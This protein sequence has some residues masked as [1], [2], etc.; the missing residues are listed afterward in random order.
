[1]SKFIIISSSMAFIIWMSI[2]WEKSKKPFYNSSI[3]VNG[4]NAI[5]D[6][7]YLS[8]INQMTGQKVNDLSKKRLINALV[9][10][11]FVHVARISNRYPSKLII[12]IKERKP[13]ALINKDPMVILDQNCYVLPVNNLGKYDIPV[14][15]KFNKDDTLYP[16][17]EKSLSIKVQN[18]IS[19]LSSLH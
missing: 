13:F 16:H 4:A 3:I 2:S 18:T 7:T 10:H 15:S 11:P 19:W 12:D 8:Y 17:G 9:T 14:L 5:N 1:M 6:T